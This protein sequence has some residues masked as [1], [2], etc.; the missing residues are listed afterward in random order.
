MTE[1]QL[2]G[3]A[4]TAA[5]RNEASEWEVLQFATATLVAPRTYELSGLLRGQAGTEG[6]MRTP[7][8]AGARFVLLGPAVTPIDMTADEVGLPFTWRFGPANRDLGHPSYAVAGALV[9]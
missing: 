5:V 3:G 1:L 9:S 6:A 7:L 2:L 8:Q 4:N